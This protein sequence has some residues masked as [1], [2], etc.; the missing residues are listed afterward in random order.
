MTQKRNPRF[1]TI[2]AVIECMESKLLI[3][4]NLV[5]GW[6]PILFCQRTKLLDK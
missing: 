2:C 3:E 5:P 1:Q 4:L 6:P